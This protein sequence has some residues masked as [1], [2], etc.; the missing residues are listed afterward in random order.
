MGKCDEARSRHCVYDFYV[1]VPCACRNDGT[2]HETWVYPK[3][4][5]DCRRFSA[6]RERVNALKRIALRHGNAILRDTTYYLT[7]PNGRWRKCQGFR[8][9]FCFHPTLLN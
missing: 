9:T 5:R 6:G 2:K 1:D 8:E 4:G 3:A 7:N